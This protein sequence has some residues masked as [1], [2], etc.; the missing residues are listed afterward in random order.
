[1]EQVFTEYLD[2]IYWQGYGLEFME[3]NPDAFYRQLNEFMEMYSFPKVI[4]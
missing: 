4:P 3:D 2:Q 1:M